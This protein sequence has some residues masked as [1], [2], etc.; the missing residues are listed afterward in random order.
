[1]AVFDEQYV[2]SNL[3]PNNQR[4]FRDPLELPDVANTLDMDDEL[5]AYSYTGDLNV[6]RGILQ[7]LT[8]KG[9]EAFGFLKNKGAMIGG[10]I[11]SAITGIPFL[12]TAFNA[13]QRPESPS[14]AMS[15]SFAYGNENAGNNYGYYDQLRHGNLTGQDE[16]GINTISQFGNY[17]AYYDNFKREMDKKK[18]E[19][20]NYKMNT[21]NQRKYNHAE[22]VAAANKERIEK[23]FFTNDDNDG[24][25]NITYTSPVVNND[26][27]GGGAQSTHTVSISP[28]QAAINQDRGRGGGGYESQ[29]GGF[30]AQDDARES[31]GR[32]DGGRIGYYFG[33]LAARGMKR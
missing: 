28:A 24:N 27:S 22:L 29:A 21:F 14:D 13:L 19:D 5:K 26:N 15:K 7:S 25:D 23:D 17:P 10:G 31:Y 32:K 9:K 3:S 11:A 1:M 30:T 12:G 8:N 33:G 16:F 18:E 6:N 4:P 20:I 2:T